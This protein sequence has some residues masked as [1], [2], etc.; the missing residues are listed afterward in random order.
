M[1]KKIILI[2]LLLLCALTLAAQITIKK[3]NKEVTHSSRLLTPTPTQPTESTLKFIP[4]EIHTNPSQTNELNIQVNSQG[5]HPDLLQFE[6]AYDPEILA[7]I[8]IT[9][10]ST[11]NANIA[12]NNNDERTG[13]LSYAAKLPQPLSSSEIPVT[14]KFKVKKN[15]LQKQTT[16]YFL[17]KTATSSKGINIPIKIAYG[18]KIIIATPSVQLKKQ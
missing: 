10:K 4:D 1:S 2:L 14:L 16:I 3:E 13:R 8:S 5:L 17:P 11:L 15:T 12:L 7:E 9:P 6:L 18:A